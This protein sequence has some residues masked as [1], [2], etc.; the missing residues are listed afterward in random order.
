MALPSP[1]NPETPIPNNPFYFPESYYVRGPYGYLIIGSGLQIDYAPGTLNAFGGGGGAVSGVFAGTGISVNSNVGNVTVTNTGVT[2]LIAGPGIS[3]SGATGSVTISSTGIGTV[4]QINTGT[5]LTGG[6]ITSSGTIS[7]NNTGVVAGSYTA[8]T[9]V[10]DAQGRLTGA[11]SNPYVS[12]I[13]ATAPVFVTPG[14]TPVISVGD[15]TLGTCGVV[16]LSSSVTSTS[17]TFAAT[18]SAVKTAYDLANAAVPKS[19]YLNVGD[20]VT[21]ASPSTVYALPV[22]ANG[23]V[24]TADSACL[25][26][27]KWDAVA[28]SGGTVTSITAGTGLTGG[29]IT[30]SGTIA[31]DTACVIAPSALTGKGAILSATAA[32]TP[33]ALPVGTNG[34]VLTANSACATGLEWIAPTA[35]IPCSV[36][37][38]K[39]SIVTATAA[40][41]PFG[42]PV[43]TDGQVLYACSTTGSGLCWASPVAAP[44]ATPSVE[45]IV[46]GCTTTAGTTAL[47]CGAL[48]SLTTGV[49]NVAVGCCALSANT[50]GCNNVAIGGASL[51][52]NIDGAFN[53]AIGSAALFYNT[54]G[55]CNIGIGLVAAAYNTGS[56][57]ISIGTQSS[58]Y[59][60]GSGTIA[61]GTRAAQTY[62]G[63]CSVIIGYEV[64]PP[65]STASQ[66]LAIGYGFSDYWLTGDAAKTIKPG[67]GVKDCNDFVGAANMVLTSQGNAIEWKPVSSAIADPNYG[68]FYSNV[69][70]TPITL[71]VGQPVDLNVTSAAN[72]FALSGG[73][74]IVAGV[75]GI[76][77]LQF[78]LQILSTAGG[79]GNVEIWLAQNGLD[80]P[81][82]NTRF[83]VKNV[84]EAEF[85]ALNYVVQLAAGESVQLV[86]ATDNANIRLATPASIM[87]GPGIP[88]AIVTI[89]PVGA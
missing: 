72:N 48:I 35:D 79:G 17:T 55:S 47:G 18:P 6:P 53:V 26:G 52:S 46:Y 24:L 59:N 56:D 51:V 37:T 75:A 77:N 39:G 80:V 2:N 10:V 36:L 34:Q 29:T 85:A 27:L 45:G 7:L 43:G 28:S 61:I 62:D 64:A 65:S 12:S 49:Q 57:N 11:T 40:N 50:I 73:S 82:S 44:P 30:T 9:I 78:S 25:G 84:N 88:S 22:G 8:P 69:P 87:G 5:G 86:W 41:T 60:T 13:T 74:Q 3:V 68:S 89:V 42:L 66:Q 21:A 70:Q 71:N 23:T 16:R 76:Y 1:F 83:S 81:D 33:S 15:A 32:S 4:T 67:A 38:A 63:N 54:N 58:Q 19:C 20:I 14:A 31:L